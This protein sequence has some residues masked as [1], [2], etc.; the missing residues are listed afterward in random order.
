MRL[1]IPILLLAAAAALLVA[2]ARCATE[3]VAEP[4][5]VFARDESGAA[6][7]NVADTRPPLIAE[8]KW[9][10]LPPLE[11]RS[12]GGTVYF[13]TNDDSSAI[14]A[15]Q[16]RIAPRSYPFLPAGAFRDEKERLVAAAPSAV[17]ADGR[18][19]TFR[20]DVAH[21][22][23]GREYEVTV[24]AADAAGNSS[25]AV[26][27]T[28]Y[29]REFPNLGAEMAREGWTIGATYEPFSFDDLATG[30]TPLLGGYSS[31]L[32]IVQAKQAD[33]ATGAGI[34]LFWLDWSNWADNP[35]KSS[36]A[37][38]VADGLS[39]L[40]G[41]RIGF[42]I[43]PQE[44]MKRGG[45]NIPEWGIDLENAHN[46]GCLLRVA[47]LVAERYARP[48]SLHRI[49]GRPV[50]FLFDERAFFNSHGTYARLRAIFRDVAGS[51]PYLIA[52]ALPR[53]PRLADDTFVTGI[54]RERRAGGLE[55]VDAF[56]CWIGGHRVTPPGDAGYASSYES[57]YPLHLESSLRF[58]SRRRK[59]FVPSVVP[60]F[61]NS[62]ARWGSPQSPLPRSPERFRE[63]L[64]LALDAAVRSGRREIRIDTW[65]DFFEQSQVEPGERDGWAFLEVLREELAA[66]RSTAP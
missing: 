41:I 64:R 50:L 8:L 46:A 19:A 23:G 63:H 29:V 49:S 51:E 59:C 16:V 27:V 44:T 18:D 11:G 28:P 4:W 20:A 25:T 53:H 48:A 40:E 43:G 66:K 60:G 30:D 15:V 36:W 5:P 31:L 62:L 14:G 17:S 56:T 45:R 21:L 26:L 42:C 52:D 1:R 7:R 57:F 55:L 3:R 38:R 39:R 10:P 13:H 61:D 58:A 37:A 34:N 9:L 6:G 12:D 35:S 65:N 47:R 32:E 2:V 24:T 33:W 22:A 54:A